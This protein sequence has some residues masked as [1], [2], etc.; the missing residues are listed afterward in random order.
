MP[1]EH[2]IPPPGDAGREEEPAYHI[3]DEIV[4]KY[5]GNVRAKVEGYE[6]IGDKWRLR[7]RA[8]VLFL[9]PPSQVVA[10]EREG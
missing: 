6:L 2:T 7:A 10:V 3:G 1:E 8:T 4:F 9:V 5:E